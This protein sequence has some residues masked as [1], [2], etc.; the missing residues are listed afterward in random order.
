MDLN[1]ILQTVN[2][3]LKEGETGTKVGALTWL[4]NMFTAQPSKVK[5]VDYR[6]YSYST[7]NPQFR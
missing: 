1:G 5:P 3:F 6:R 7:K 2:R 4:Y